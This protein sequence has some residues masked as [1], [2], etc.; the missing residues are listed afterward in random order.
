MAHAF[1]FAADVACLQ[2]LIGVSMVAGFPD[3]SNSTGLTGSVG[4]VSN[5]VI[6]M[7]YL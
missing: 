6:A 2:I 5:K 3:L 7:Y 1:Y 4:G